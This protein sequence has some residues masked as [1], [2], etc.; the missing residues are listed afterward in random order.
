MSVL[1]EIEVSNIVPKSMEA[2]FKISMFKEKSL[3]FQETIIKETII[4]LCK[5]DSFQKDYIN[6]S[7]NLI[8]FKLNEKIKRPDQIDFFP[9]GG[10][11]NTLSKINEESYF[12]KLINKSHFSL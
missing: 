4:E 1:S 2:A 12:P 6:F 11:L 7:L 3:R 5:N 10:P 9:E 8:T